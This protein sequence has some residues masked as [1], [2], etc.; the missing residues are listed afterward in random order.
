MEGLQSDTG[1]WP[2]K[3][4]L[5]VAKFRISFISSA[6]PVRLFGASDFHV[7]LVVIDEIL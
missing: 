1:Y 7:V 2:L 3:M 6:V 4:H 5:T